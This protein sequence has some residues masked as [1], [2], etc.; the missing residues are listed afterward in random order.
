MV[1]MDFKTIEKEFEKKHTTRYIYTE[2]QGY[3][4]KWA[5]ENFEKLLLKPTFQASL[6]VNLDFQIETNLIN[7]IDSE[8]DKLR[9]FYHR[10]SVGLQ[11]YLLETNDEVLI[12]NTYKDFLNNFYKNFKDYVSDG[13]IPWIFANVMHK[14]VKQGSLTYEPKLYLE[15]CFQKFELKMMKKMKQYL[16]KVANSLP[17]D[18]TYQ[19]LLKAYDEKII[20]TEQKLQQLKAKS[21]A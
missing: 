20:K 17:N 18:Q 7:K 21:L 14:K 8:I 16:K 3:E 9:E 1:E 12:E 10:T 15:L 6:S 11:K 5:F 2:Y 4:I 19:I 13:L